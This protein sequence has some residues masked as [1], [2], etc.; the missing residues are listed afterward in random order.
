MQGA[1]NRSTYL[2][3]G[4]YFQPFQAERS[5]K[6][7]GNVMSM[8]LDRWTV[9]NPNPNAFSPRL[10]YGSNANNYKTSTWWQR[11]ASYLRVKNVELGYTLPESLT[12]KIHAK[13]MRVYLQG[14]NLLTISKFY[15]NFWDPE[16]GA[17][18]YPMQKTIF[19]GL[20]LLF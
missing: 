15:K 10:S 13:S 4:W 17:D 14:V 3:G 16:T 19:L 7:M 11:D 1:G 18:A 2:T 6:Y 20:N 9:D 12:Q 8:L 5:P